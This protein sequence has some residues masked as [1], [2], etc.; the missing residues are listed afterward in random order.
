MMEDNSTV[1]IIWQLQEL[2]NLSSLEGYQYQTHK[3]NSIHQGFLGWEKCIEDMKT[4]CG[5]K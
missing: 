1:E 4:D 3:S 5:N 2:A